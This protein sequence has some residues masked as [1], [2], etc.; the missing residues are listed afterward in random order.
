MTDRALTAGF[1]AETVSPSPIGVVFAEFMFT[2]PVRV[3]TGLGD[4]VATM[5]GG[6]SQTWVGVG[7][8]GGIES[9]TE[10]A[11]RRRNGVLFSLSGVDTSLLDDVLTDNYQ[12][13]DVTVWEAY[14]DD[15]GALIADP[16]LAFAG[17]MDTMGIVDG[18]PTGIIKL[19][20]ENRDVLLQRTSRSLYTNEQQQLDFP[21]DLG[22]EFIKELQKK[23]IIWGAPNASNTGFVGGGGGAKGGDTVSRLR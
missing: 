20:C 22:L 2:T 16:G 9:I 18:D 19:Q 3:W 15:N 11:D 14:I 6:S 21:G 13:K 17:L 8:L 4:K 23:Q 5:P 12:G 7:D 1:K 10:S